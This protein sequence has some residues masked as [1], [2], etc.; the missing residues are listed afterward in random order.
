MTYVEWNKVCGSE[1]WIEK[2]VEIIC[3]VLIE[4]ISVSFYKGNMEKAMTFSL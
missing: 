4:N 2:N 1:W 3:C